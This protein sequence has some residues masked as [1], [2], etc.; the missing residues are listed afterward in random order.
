MARPVGARGPWLVALWLLGACSSDAA[1]PQPE[2]VF[3]R[4]ELLDPRTCQGCHPQHYREWA[5]SMHAYAAEDPVFLA[6]NARGQRETNGELGDFCVKCHAPMALSEG[7]TVDG[8]NMAEV[9]EALRGVTCYFC[10][11]TEAVEGTHNNPL[12]LAN[13]LTMRGGI[14][15]PVPTAAHRS[16]YSELHD[17]TQAASAT[18]C[19]ACHDIVNG[20]GVHLERTFEEWKASLY[21]EEQRGL[22]TCSACHMSSQR[23][24]VIAEE[25]GVTTPPRRSHEHLFAGVDVALTDFPDTELQRAAIECALQTTVLVEMIVTQRREIIITLE[26]DAGHAWPTG[27]TQDRRAWLELVVTKGEQTLL[28]TGVVA[29]DEWVDKPRMAADYDPNLWLLRDRIFDAEAQPTHLFWDAAPSQTYPEG[30]VSNLLPVPP[31]D[32]LPHSE[33]R[34][35]LLLD[36]PDDVRVAVHIRPMGLDVIDD[37]IESGDLDPVI[38]ERIPTFT[39]ALTELEWN[40]ERDG[41]GRVLRMQTSPFDC[42]SHYRDL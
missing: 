29:D 38:R 1:A 8:L 25:T 35:F 27:A 26:T 24:Q 3:S 11:T 5:S 19:G 17:S 20:H 4:Q 14:A 12:V 23:N 33:E 37:L 18:A 30:L 39:L 28:E 31:P 6:M 2:L 16:A 13:D 34:T 42:P 7:A 32:L 15:D 10:H 41:Y 36:D 9:P 22:Q 21:A 40:R